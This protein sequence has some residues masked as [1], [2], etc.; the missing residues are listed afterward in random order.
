MPG[1]LLNFHCFHL[2][3]KIGETRIYMRIFLNWGFYARD[4][5]LSTPQLTPSSGIS[6]HKKWADRWRSAR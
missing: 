4:R 5:L 2:L 3:S 6:G 1:E